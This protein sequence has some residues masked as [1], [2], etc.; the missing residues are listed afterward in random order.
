MKKDEVTI[1]S[2]YQVMVTDKLAPVRIDRV[3][4]QGGWIGTNMATKRV[5]HIK[6]ANRLRACVMQGNSD[7]NPPKAPVTPEVDSHREEEPLPQ[8]RAKKRLKKQATASHTTEV[9]RE[10]ATHPDDPKP[11]SKDKKTGCLDAAVRV[12]KEAGE[13]QTSGQIMQRIL[14]QRLW[15]TAGRTPAATLY[16]AMLREIQRK[17]EDAR[18]VLARPGKFTL[19]R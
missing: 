6:T 7:P 8:H 1:G 18:F 10:P 9:Q 14:D 15:T 19:N 11:T 3:H 17:G 4:E 13:P 12:L 5:V 16:S 2:V